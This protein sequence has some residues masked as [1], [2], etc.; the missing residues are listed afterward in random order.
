MESTRRPTEDSFRHTAA[1]EVG[2]SLASASV[3]RSCGSVTH[4]GLSY[5][6]ILFYTQGRLLISCHYEL[7]FSRDVVQ[8]TMN[9]FTNDA[10]CS[11]YFVIYC[12]YCD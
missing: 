2:D 9:Y 4:V 11:F 8:V 1:G 7:F 12:A 6:R 3:R 10:K 5:E